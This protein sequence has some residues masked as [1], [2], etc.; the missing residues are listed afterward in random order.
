MPK[1]RHAV[2]RFYY[3]VPAKVTECHD[4]GETRMCEVVVSDPEPETGYVDEYALC[5]ACKNGDTKREDPMGWLRH[6]GEQV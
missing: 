1:E 3:S 2:K 5:E 4:C 6:Q